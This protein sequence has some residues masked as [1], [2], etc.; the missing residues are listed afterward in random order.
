M[1]LMTPATV[2]AGRTLTVEGSRGIQSMIILDGRVRVV[3]DGHVV[4][5][6]GAGAVVGEIAI[7]CRV[8]RTATVVTEC[9]TILEVMTPPELHALMREHRPLARS[10]DLA[11]AER[12]RGGAEVLAS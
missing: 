7:L 1:R 4:A 10:V 2:S 12:L 8:P 6:L 5:T 9:E 3:R 11:M